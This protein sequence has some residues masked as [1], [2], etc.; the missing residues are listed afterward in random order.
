M[1]PVPRNVWLQNSFDN[2]AVLQRTFTTS[3][4]S[5]L[6]IPSPVSLCALSSDWKRGA[7]VL[8]N[9]PPYIC[10]PRFFRLPVQPDQFLLAAF[11]HQSQPRALSFQPVIASLKPTRA[12]T[13]ANV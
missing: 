11:L 13:L 12:L 10:I 4:V 5:R 9:P 7:S 8:R 1:I 2:P 6:T 3:D